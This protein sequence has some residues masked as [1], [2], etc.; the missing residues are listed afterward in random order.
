MKKQSN[1]KRRRS[2]DPSCKSWPTSTDAQSNSSS[3]FSR[4]RRRRK[5]KR[6]TTVR[7]PYLRLSVSRSSLRRG[8]DKLASMLLKGS[9]LKN[10][11]LWRKSVRKRGSVW[12]LKKQKGRP[13]EQIRCSNFSS[14]KTAI[15]R[16]Q[17]MSHPP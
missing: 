2:T 9:V 15:V 12:Q 3:K 17:K 1:A 7:L 10:S 16:P 4:T 14:S 5:S 8:R 11:L 13:Q 6:S